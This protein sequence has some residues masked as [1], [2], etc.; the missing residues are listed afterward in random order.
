MLLSRMY[1]HKYGRPFDTVT[2]S[3]SVKLSKSVAHPTK[4]PAPVAGM[5]GVHGW[6][7]RL[8][9]AKIHICSGISRGLCDILEEI[10]SACNVVV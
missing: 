2:V 1:I 6:C 5:L 10:K 8:G 9:I 7:S 3:E 4:I